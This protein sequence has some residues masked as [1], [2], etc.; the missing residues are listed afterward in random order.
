MSVAVPLLLAGLLIL[1]LRRF[2]LRRRRVLRGLPVSGPWHLPA[3]FRNR[4]R[5][6]W[7]R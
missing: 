1:L 7:K 4:P 5:V 2:I 6:R 3:W